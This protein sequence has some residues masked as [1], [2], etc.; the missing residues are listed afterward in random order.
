M[1]TRLVRFT[2]GSGNRSAATELADMIIP[3]IRAQQG[4]KSVRLIM[5]DDGDEMGFVIQWATREDA[6]AASQVVG[7][8]LMPAIAAIAASPA[9]VQLFEDYEL[10]A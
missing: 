6:D 10:T 3:V 4:C 2:L 1:Y 5:E 9:V 7:P 8:K